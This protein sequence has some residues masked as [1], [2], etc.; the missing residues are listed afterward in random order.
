MEAAP[1]RW[2]RMLRLC[3]ALTALACHS[4]ELRRLRA[5][6][7][8][9]ESARRRAAAEVSRLRQL[10]E[11]RIARNPAA[12]GAVALMKEGHDGHRKVTGAMVGSGYCLFY[13]E[14]CASLAADL[15]ELSAARERYEEEAKIL[16]G[17]IDSLERLWMETQKTSW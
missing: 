12:A 9:R 8:L 1:N 16:T 13:G 3:A 14:E 7:E 6:I 5:E 17:E 15:T 2:T 11:A 4:S 10:T